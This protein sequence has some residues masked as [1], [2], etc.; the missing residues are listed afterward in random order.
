MFARLVS[1][2]GRHRYWSTGNLTVSRTQLLVLMDAS[3]CTQLK[4]WDDAQ[5]K[6]RA[7]QGNGH[8]S[9]KVRATGWVEAM[10]HSGVLTFLLS[11]ACHH[12]ANQ[13]GGRR[14]I[15]HTW[16]Q[17][18][19]VPPI[20]KHKRNSTQKPAAEGL[21]QSI[22]A[23]LTRST[24]AQEDLCMQWLCHCH[25]LCCCII[26]L[27]VVQGSCGAKLT[28]ALHGCVRS[29]VGFDGVHRISRRDLGVK[30]ASRCSGV[31]R[32]PC[33]GVVLTTTGLA[34]AS[35]AISG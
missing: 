33:S 28:P 19:L 7:G 35:R 29:P 9:L 8:R 26:P 12:E 31:I 5:A 27:L 1:I 30:A 25:P 4:F 21:T 14:K 22:S 20:D 2:Q 16:V 13:R 23:C 10:T 17:C 32:K 6:E 3:Q 15:L 34:P 18:Q 11:Q 24:A